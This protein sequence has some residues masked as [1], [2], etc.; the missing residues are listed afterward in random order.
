[1]AR[2]FADKI[3]SKTEELS[4]AIADARAENDAKNPVVAEADTP[5]TKQVLVISLI[6]N[7]LGL[8]MPLA[9]FQ[10]Y[11]RILPN[12]AGATLFWLITGLLAAVILDTILRSLRSYILGWAA[13][14]N[15]HRAQQLAMNQLLNANPGERATITRSK[16]LDGLDA[17]AEYSNFQGSQNRT[18]LI[19]IPMAFIFLAMVALVGGTLVFVPIVLIIA[20]GL[21][22]F[23]QGKEIQSFLDNR[24]QQDTRQNDFLLETFSNIQTVKNLA[25]ES[26]LLRR[27]EMLQKTSTV[28]SYHAIISTNKLQTQGVVFSNMMM[29]CVVSFGAVRVIGGDMSLAALACCSLLTGRMVQPFARALT[30]FH[31]IQNIRL[32]RKRCNV[33]DRIAN[34]GL[35]TNTNAES[36]TKGAFS[37]RNLVLPSNDKNA[38]IEPYNLTATPGEFIGIHCQENAERTEFVSF[39]NGKFVPESGNVFADGFSSKQWHELG[40]NRE[41]GFVSAKTEIFEGTIIDNLTM[42]GGANLVES[43]REASRLIGLE[44]DIFKLPDGYDTVLS[45]GSASI[46]SPGFLQRIKIAR[47]IRRQ[48][49]IFIFDGANSNMDMRS[50]KLLADGLLTLKG[51][52]TAVYFSSRPSFLKI[53]DQRLRMQDGHL[54]PDDFVQPKADKP[55]AQ[56]AS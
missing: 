44:Q 8:A 47:A 30:L 55:S 36:L 39:L 11:D 16:W 49:K 17:I 7:L 48:P 32:A 3:A 28:S 9:I 5:L 40:I 21:F 43:A 54:L 52:M 23:L 4:S 41:I 27:F 10:V 46:L 14:K 2:K 29:I 20:F 15:G 22:S 19:D 18:I 12:Q 53:C 1:M 26:Q 31:E 42:F 33:F 51:K 50:D 6:A 25:V 45:I 37:I 34:K 38:D 13:L 24:S 35:Q 56:S